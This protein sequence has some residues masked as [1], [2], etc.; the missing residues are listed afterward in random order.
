MQKYADNVLNSNGRPV[1]K[2]AVAVTTFPAGVPATLYSDNGITPIA[3]NVV[4][5]DSLGYFYFYAA[6]GRYTITIT[7][8]ETET[9]VRTDVLLE[10]PA[11]GGVGGLDG[12]NGTDMV[13]GTWFN[14]ASARV[15]ALAS[16]T[17]AA[18]LGFQPSG[19]GYAAISI[20]DQLNQLK[21]DYSGKGDIGI[22]PPE[23]NPLVPY[24]G[25]GAKTAISS[26]STA[27]HVGIA[28][29]TMAIAR[30]AKGS[31][32]NGPAQKDFG[33]II[34]VDKTDYKTSMEDGE[35]G[36]L[37]LVAR[38]GRKGDVA[39]ILI[40]VSK[41]RSGTAD[42]IGGAT[43][44][45]VRS[46]I[47]TPDGTVTQAVH[48]IPGF[49]EGAGGV[50]GGK[51]FGQSVESRCGTW[52]SGYH[53]GATTIGD[54]AYEGANGF[55]LAFSASTSRNP[56]DVFYGVEWATGTIYQGKPANRRTITYNPAND[57][58]QIKDETG[59]N[60]LTL[61]GA[62]YVNTPSGYQIGSGAVKTRELIL[63]GTIDPPSIAAN[64]T[65][66][67]AGLTVA[68]AA[69]GDVVEAVITSASSAFSPLRVFGT[70]TATDT[71]TLKATNTTA[72]PLDVG[73]FSYVVIVRRYL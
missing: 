29:G 34:S 46:E 12:P 17:G 65:V 57:L 7:S 2:A 22:G 45:E 26:T 10:D 30:H 72:A 19:S 3:S 27:N 15:S 9:V 33:L 63:R 71:V 24:G 50:S 31:G 32:L 4:T 55:T 47:T 23:Q 44:I 61:D 41:I 58:W 38:Q 35:I 25:H 66:D 37:I 40:D 69:L 1:E 39:G 52:F 49:S 73:T 59:A 14:G 18:F 70:V 64:T 42:D 16:A 60:L 36:S 28:L 68:G 67:L 5:T 54:G 6:D 11:D 62:G 20:A 13:N 43:P 48:N 8:P 21:S 51:G 53:V 56:A